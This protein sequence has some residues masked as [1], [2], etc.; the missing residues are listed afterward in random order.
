MNCQVNHTKFSQS[1]KLCFIVLALLQWT[2]VSFSICSRNPEALMTTK[3]IC[4]A[5]SSTT[6]ISLK[7]LTGNIFLITLFDVHI[8]TNNVTVF[9]VIQSML[10]ECLRLHTKFANAF[11]IRKGASRFEFLKIN[12]S[13]NSLLLV[14]L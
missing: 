9:L 12:M 13:S 8:Q 4:P 14:S 7:N 11:L 2:F 3:M 10:K 6:S 1:W 5:V